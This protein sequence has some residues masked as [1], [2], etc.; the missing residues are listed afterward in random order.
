MTYE[1]I[2]GL[3]LFALVSSL[4]PGPNNLMLMASAANFGFRR[5]L[6][7][8][9]GVSAGFA[10]MVI[11]IGTGISGVFDRYPMSVHALRALSVLYL[12]YLAIRLAGTRTLAEN[13]APRR[14]LTFLEAALFQWI[15]PKAWAMALT[16]VSVYAPAP[17]IIAIASVAA[18]FGLVNLPSV[19]LWAL[20]GQHLGR[21]LRHER[22]LQRFNVAMATLLLVSL[23][24]LVTR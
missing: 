10:V 15:N 11:L 22:H 13:G 19:S 18:V 23:L 3:V 24:P 17:G 5:T 20:L 1:L 9:L 7:H 16:A 4:T 2:T 12:G 6:P 8:L 14:P 21:L